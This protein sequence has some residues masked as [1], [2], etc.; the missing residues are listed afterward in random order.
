MAKVKANAVRVRA[1]A[2][3]QWIKPQLT[4]LVDEP[5]DRPDWL[6]EIII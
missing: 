6:H 3:P 4:K 1:A 5:P 2:V